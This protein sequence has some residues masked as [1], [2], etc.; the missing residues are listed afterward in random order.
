MNTPYI[1][2]RTIELSNGPDIVGAV[3]GPFDEQG[4]SAAYKGLRVLH[5]SD[6]LTVRGL[7]PVDLRELGLAVA[8]PIKARIAD[9]CECGAPYDPEF[10]GY[11]CAK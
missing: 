11:T 10:G 2:V 9:R 4:C 8:E 3:Y 7:L 1:I 6:T 5:P